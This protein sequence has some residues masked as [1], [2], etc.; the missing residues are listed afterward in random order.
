MAKTAINFD[1]INEVAP[2]NFSGFISTADEAFKYHVWERGIVKG[3]HI[4]VPTQ[5]VFPHTQTINGMPCKVASLII[6][7]YDPN[8][9]LKAI[10]TMAL[11]LLTA[12]TYGL[13][14]SCPDT[15]G[16]K[17]SSKKGLF[18]P[19]RAED[20]PVID[21]G[22]L[23][24]KRVSAP[25]KGLVDLC[26][27]EPCF[28][29]AGSYVAFGVAQKAIYGSG[30]L[31]ELTPE[32]KIKVGTK[33]YQTFKRVFPEASPEG[34]E[35]I[36]VAPIPGATKVATPAMGLNEIPFQGGVSLPRKKILCSNAQDLFFSDQARTLGM[37][38]ATRSCFN[39]CQRVFF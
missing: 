31:Y 35:K 27:S 11:S 20:I 24:L 3:W 9:R 16:A 12:R 19:E 5:R 32:G 26:V 39:E 10:D 22:S 18:L 4:A 33:R 15:I 30:Q 34:L 29:E 7:V 37:T 23:T 14:K 2:R 17:E 13:R 6:G 25:V 38:S 8:W 28:F 36:Q 1:L 21:G